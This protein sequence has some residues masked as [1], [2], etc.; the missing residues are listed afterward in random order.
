MVKIQ[1]IKRMTLGLVAFMLIMVTPYLSSAASQFTD[2]EEGS[3]HYEGIM[4]L[5]DHGIKGYE[6]GVFGKY[7]EL[8]RQHAAIMFVKVLDLDLPPKDEV[9]KYFTDVQADH[10][11]A[12]EIAAVGKAGIFKGNKNDEFSPLD[13]LTRQQMATTIVNA[14]DLD[15]A[16]KHVDIDLTDVNS[17]HEDN[18]Q[19]LAD[20]GIT[21]QLTD[22]KPREFITRGQFAT[23]LFESHKVHIGEV[24]EPNEP[25]PKEKIV[26]ETYNYT[27]SSMIN[28]Q[29]NVRPQTDSAGT[30]YDASQAFV[31]YYVNPNN[32]D[33]GTQDYY[34]FLRLSGSA[35]IS[36]QELNNRVL[37][38]KGILAGK[39]ADFIKASETH[40][41]NEIY[42]IAH[43]L[44]ET[45]H[46]TSTLAKGV[47]V[48][49]NSNGK[50]TRVTSSNRS[51][52][53]NI[54]TTYNFFGIGAY[55]N[56]ALTCGSE[57]A[58]NEG[59]FSPGA[60]II[61]GAKFIGEK[62]ISV[63]QDTLYKM[64]WNPD[65]PATHQY[66]TDAGWAVKQTGNIKNMFDLYNDIDELVLTFEV[67]RYN[68]QPAAK[69][70][71]TGEQVFNVD[72]SH[73]HAGKTGT[74]TASA[75]NFRSGPTTRFSAVDI[76]SNG[77]RVNIIG[78][79]TGWYK[80]S[81][82]NKTGWVS[83][84]YI[85][86]G[87]ARVSSYGIAS[88][89]EQNGPTLEKE[90]LL[91]Q[92]AATNRVIAEI[93]ADS[94]FREDA[95]TED[96]NIIENL[97]EGDK[98][99]ILKEKQEWFKVNHELKEGWV[100]SDSITITNVFNTVDDVEIKDSPNG[101]TIDNLLENETVIVVPNEEDELTKDGGWYNIYYHG[102][103]AWIHEDDIQ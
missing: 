21:N 86:E 95:E 99:D 69:A 30:W 55:D 65:K 22:F 23:F 46:G 73:R 81:V 58:Y 15:S 26:T 32:F 6:T 52:L 12:R 72:T 47:E 66:A 28:K 10:E 27:F 7:K 70:R 14:Y 93:N 96:D 48:G 45:G 33:Q 67:P 29:M 89:D 68:S 85:N 44:L 56:C 38:G 75:L 91:T 20:L 57:R 53:K 25:S 97:S 78:E 63:G 16:G 100:D 59:W 82:G 13:E 87:S 77:T 83:A 103:T 101:E 5:A 61:G 36:A 88:S 4:W 18:V 42:L 24:E 8:N 79:N 74:V 39:A 31:E 35:D 2:V 11:Y 76:L 90:A 60:A 50:A 49:Q 102:I 19:V 37:A 40:N 1:R 3:T 9:E 71:P 94:A 64:R 54:K 34:Q 80:V 92:Q 41:V 62:Y 43:A 84:A 17:S 51:Q 98:V